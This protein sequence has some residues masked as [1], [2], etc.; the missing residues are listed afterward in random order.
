MRMDLTVVVPCFDEAESLSELYQ[1]LTAILQ[2]GGWH[3][4]ILFV[5]D[6]S[7][8]FS[9]RILEELCF[10]DPRVG[11]ITFRRNFGKAA[12]LDAGFREA[13]G[14]V[15][16]TLDADLQDQ[17]SE[18]PRLVE[19]LGEGFDL[20]SGWKRGRKD[21]LT[22]TIPSAIFNATVRL[23]SRLQLRD[24]NSGLKA[25][26]GEVVEG[27]HLYGEMHRFI[28]VLAHWQGFLVTEIPVEHRPRRFGRSKYGVAR[29]G[30]GFFDLLT[31]MLNTR[32]HARPLHLFGWVG[33]TIGG[34]GMLSLVYLV[35]LWFLD[36]GPIGNR[37]LLLFGA[38]MV[39]VGIQLVSTGLL[40]ELITREQ[41]ARKPTYAIR[42]FVRPGLHH[43]QL[44]EVPDEE[45]DDE[46]NHRSIHASGVPTGGGAKAKENR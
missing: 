11:V 42:S 28:P 43:Q 30:K 10:K 16:V 36:R 29:L 8:D 9:Q 6:G 21:P 23:V 31:V 32:F 17:P 27:L 7:T 39:M 1:Q 34:V 14:N 5:D 2:K 44:P 24:L 38:L 13:R 33:A 40:G 15:V 37:P 18:I 25:Y 20:V 46:P 12:A 4:E 26:R 35:V 41:Q 45:P 19:R 22:K 3:F